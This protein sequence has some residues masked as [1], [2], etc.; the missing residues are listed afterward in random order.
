VSLTDGAF[1]A[2]TLAVGLDLVFGEPPSRFHPVV[3]IGHY[4]K[5]V[6]SRWH[7]SEARTQLLE[8]GLGWLFGAIG[9]VM[10]GFALQRGLHALPFAL[11][12]ALTAV[13][14]KPLFAVRALFN[15][16]GQVLKPLEAGDLEAAR[17]AL[18]THLVSRSTTDLR[19][20][21]I[22]GAT[23]ESLFENL[24]DSVIAPIL[25]FAVGGLPLALLYR[26]G[27]TADAI[28]GYRT[29][30][31]EYR[32]KIAARADD[33]LNLIP[34]RV[35]GALIVLAAVFDTGTPSQ[36]HSR[37]YVWEREQPVRC[38]LVSKKREQPVRCE[39]VSKNGV[40][41]NATRTWR[42]MTRDSR[43]TASP[44]AGVPMSAA[45]GA[46]EVRL[47]K[48]GHYALN[49]D[50]RAPTVEDV[51]HGVRLAQ[52]ALFIGVFVTAGILGLRHA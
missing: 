18:G 35:T 15:A 48:R 2:L 49:P 41:E 29:P 51:V 9:V 6:R 8:G 27:N 20:D 14:L 32:G 33:A 10:I 5:F 4:L 21:E 12:V 23:I 34:A 31:L 42:V 24:S 52:R 25:A 50:A 26:Y 19:Q 37:E 22:A 40:L 39:S 17:V 30:E 47:E 13:V 3:W 44:N 7:A 16:V 1:V 43:L 36:T 38:C 45:A 46:L 11:E 28:W